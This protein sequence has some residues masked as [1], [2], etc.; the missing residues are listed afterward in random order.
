MM[1]IC[2]RIF[3][4]AIAALLTTPILA[5]SIDIN[6]N[7]ALEGDLGLETTFD[8]AGDAYA[9]SDAPDAETN[10][11][12]SFLID[13]NNLSIP[14]GVSMLIGNMRLSPGISGKRNFFFVW[15]RRSGA[16]GS[17]FY[18]IQTNVRQDDTSFP[19]WQSA[20]KICSPTGQGDIPC[21]V[22]PV[23][24]EFRWQAA[25]APGAND[26][27]MEVYKDDTLVR[28]FANLDNDTHTLDAG[29][30]GSIFNQ[31]S[32][33]SD[34]TGSYYLDDFL[35]VRSSDAVTP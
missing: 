28:A 1:K 33:A 12:F 25:T 11:S 2:C 31:T 30:W 15:I 27:Y 16:P 22:V 13:P 20:I 8:G 17:D 32:P 4:L 29:W 10:Y 24:F 9:V 6:A 35:A 26:G 7:A 19:S 34:V 3:V 5:D 23:K 21:T 18:E 14:N